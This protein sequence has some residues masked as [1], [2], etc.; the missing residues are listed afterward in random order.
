M[1]GRD[2]MPN[3]GTPGLQADELLQSYFASTS[4]SESS[5]LLEVLLCDHAQPIVRRIVKAHLRTSNVSWG[6][7]LRAPHE[8]A[9]DL[10]SRV[11][12]QLLKR[13][14]ELK[15]D[16]GRRS[17]DGF[18]N[19]VAVA[20]YNACHES[21]RQKHPERSRLKD[22]LRYI[23]TRQGGFALWTGEN[24]QML[25][26]FAAWSARTRPASPSLDA[27]DLDRLATHRQAVDLIAAVFTTIGGPV[28]F[29]TLVAVV[30]QVQGLGDGGV[31]VRDARAL[32]RL[33]DPHLD[34][35]TRIEL[36]MQLTRLWEEIC[37]LPLAQ[38]RALLL[39]LRDADGGSLAIVLADIRIASL[40]EIA[41]VLDMPPLDLAELWKRIPLDDL[42]VAERFG[43][44]REQVIHQ[45]QSARRRLARRLKQF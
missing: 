6:G 24:G 16:A 10:N 17:I 30:A 35:A 42:T 14:Q 26:G 7:G 36:R 3:V 27:A 43:V 11:T 38:R 33:A 21:L 34:A 8:D 41:A 13:L 5:S 29:D 40:H 4:E 15:A 44:T 31:V 2:S 37:A 9:D 18:R 22:K 28:A 23:L 1:D 39:G 19:Y 32:E 12:L 45:R 25:C 20:A